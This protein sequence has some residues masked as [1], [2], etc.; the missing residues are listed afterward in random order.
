M[1]A[2][3]RRP[4]A[5]PLLL[6]LACGGLAAACN[7]GSRFGWSLVL[8]FG[9]AV[10]AAYATGMVVA[11]LLFRTF[12]F[13]QAARPMREQVSAFVLVNL[14]GMALTLLLSI[15]LADLIFPAIGL[16]F[17]AEAIAHLLAVGAPIATSWVGHRRLTFR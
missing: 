2:R 3:A 6:F 8:P 9:A 16:R 10:V 14:L 7:W 15:L 17:H 12:V 11:F 4:A 5:N 1:A 13:P